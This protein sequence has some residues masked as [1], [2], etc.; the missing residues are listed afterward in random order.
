M[1]A[2]GKTSLFRAAGTIGL[3]TLFSRILGF[4]RDIIIANYFGTRAAADAFFMAFRIPSL[5]RRLTAEGALSAAFVPLFAKT[6]L[7]DRREAFRLANNLIFHMTLFTTLIVVAGVTFTPWLLKIIAVGFIDDPQKFQLTVNLTRLVFPYLLFISLAAIIMGILNSLHHFAAPAAAPILLNVSFILCI[8]LLRDFFEL[9]VYALAAGVLIGGFLQL[10]VQI[11]FAV[12]NGFVF[13]FVF[14]P[15]SALL[16]KV[17]LLTLPATFGV[18]VAEVNMFVDTMLASML[19]EGSISYLYYAN[20][21]MLFPMGIFAI[22][23]STALLP[24]LSYHA[25]KNEPQKMIEKLS[26][27]L[28]TMML[29][30]MPSMVGLIAL[31]VPIIEILFERG[32]FDHSSTLNTGFALACYSSGLLAFSGVKLFTAAFYALGDTKTPVILATLAMV[33]NIVLNLLLMGPLAHGG[34]ALATSIA[35]WVNIAGLAIILR[36]RLGT[37]DGPSLLKSFTITGTASVVMAAFIF[38]SWEFFFGGG[39]SPAGLILIITS[40][41]ILYFILCWIMGS[42]EIKHFAVLLKEKFGGKTKA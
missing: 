7:K 32:A 11:P 31:R 26:A 12:K 29:L 25:G 34:L 40:A 6:L 33:L 1:A 13:S 5:L 8:I 35:S 37:I 24:A 18:A 3:L 15:R 42:K 30:I 10:A 22:S 38:F 23:I 16:K 17:V 20:R 14:D 27:S 41:S 39:H 36:K 19:K 4:L 21:M 9:P 2:G 28:R